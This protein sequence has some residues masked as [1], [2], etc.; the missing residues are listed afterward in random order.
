MKE[1]IDKLEA[2]DKNIE[3]LSL[4]YNGLEELPDVLASFQNLVSLDLSHNK[5]KVFPT[6]ILALRN[7]RSLTLSHNKLEQIPDAINQLQHLNLLVLNSN[8]LE[9]FPLAVLQLT[10][11]HKLSLIRCP[12]I[13]IPEE[14][15]NLQELKALYLQNTAL[16]SLPKTLA[17][18]PHLSE[19]NIQAHKIRQFPY[20]LLL[21]GQLP[22]RSARIL[23]SMLFGINIGTMQKIMRMTSKLTKIQAPLALRKYAF[24]VLTGQKNTV[25]DRRPLFD[26]L[27]INYP[28]LNKKTWQLINAS[29]ST[30][31]ANSPL[32]KNSTICLLGKPKVLKKLATQERLEQSNIQYTQKITEQ[33]THAVLVPPLPKNHQVHN[34]PN[35]VFIT[36]QDLHQFLKAKEGGFLLEN[37][38]DAELNRSNLIELLYST[39]EES[40]RL[41]VQLI[42]GGGLDQ[43]LI[44]PLFIAYT[45][46]QNPALRKTIRQ[47]LY[48]NIDKGGQQ[49]LRGRI[50]FYAPSMREIEICNRLIRYQKACSNLDAQQIA[51]FLYKKYQKAYTYLVL[52][53]TAAQQKQFLAQFINT[54]QIFDFSSLPNLHKLPNSLAEYQNLIGINLQGCSFHHFPEVLLE[55]TFPKLKWVDLRKTYIRKLPYPLPKHLE[56]CK[57]FTDF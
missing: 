47:L 19:L 4:A 42:D 43:T 7:L 13:E 29:N 45:Y 44:T 46:V 31:L 18:L 22:A 34:Y 23:D 11:L 20:H 2:K 16:K 33:T 30:N 37:N 48:I 40:I 5:L 3:N 39:Q 9:E 8:P 12:K 57:F 26:L 52:H 10:K 35:L 17:N 6:Q 51:L 56:D 15:D 54:Q 53:T 21:L 49:L 1:L 28:P 41:G 55:Q 38:Q 50:S 27:R 24:E 36:E 25:A 14:I 32:T